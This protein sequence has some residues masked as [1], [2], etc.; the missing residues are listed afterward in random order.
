MVGAAVCAQTN[1]VPSKSPASTNNPAKPKS[2]T[3][4]IGLHAGRGYFDGNA[5]QVV[6]FDHVV[7]TNVQGRLACER[8]TINLPPADSSDSHPTNAVAE[9]NLDIVFVDNKGVTN[10]LTADKGIYDYRVFHGVTNETLTF[11][12]HAT[13]TSADYWF[14]GEPLV[15]DNAKNNFDFGSHVDM[16]FKVTST[17][18]NSSSSPF[19]LQK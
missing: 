14:T 2:S 15:W 10:H 1:P 6:Y 9:T 16:H 5:R 7:I 8:L 17:S 3:Q 19:N 13:N 11:T 18:S 12:G 4:E